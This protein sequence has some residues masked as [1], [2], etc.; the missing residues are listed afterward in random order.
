MPNA[1]VLVA[2][3]GVALSSTALAQFRAADPLETRVSEARALETTPR[4]GMLDWA[5]EFSMTDNLENFPLG[6]LFIDAP[7]SAD[8]TAFTAPPGLIWGPN[9]L[10]GQ[11]VP[12]NPREWTSVVDLANEPVGPANT[13]RGLRIRTDVAQNP[14]GFFVGIRHEWPIL[15]GVDGDTPVRLHADFFATSLGQLYTFE[16]VDTGLSNLISARLLW[17]GD[18]EAHELEINCVELAPA[19]DLNAFVFLSDCLGARCFGSQFWPARYCATRYGNA[20]EGCE[21]PPFAKIGDIVRP[22]VGSW[23]QLGYEISPEGTR[24]HTI[25]YMDGTG[26]HRFAIDAWFI[27][28]PYV[29]RLSVN[30]SF[31][32]ADALLYVDNI[33]ASGAGG[34]LLDQ[35]DFD[36]PFLNDAN[37]LNEGLL[38]GQFQDALVGS[39]GF[40]DRPTAYVVP[41]HNGAPGDLAIAIDPDETPGPQTGLA[42]QAFVPI[43]RAE[44]FDIDISVEVRHDNSR[45]REIALR[46]SSSSSSAGTIVLSHPAQ[47]NIQ[48]AGGEGVQILD[49]QWPSDNEYHSLTLR[50]SNN[51][52]IRVSIDG[53]PVGTAAGVL[54]RPPVVNFLEFRSVRGGLFEIDNVAA[55]CGL[56]SCASDVNLDDVTNFADLNAVLSNF[57]Q[58]GDAVPGDTNLDGTV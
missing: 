46:A 55:G 27:G 5:G 2:A 36:C 18:C 57:G 37:Y 24:S 21:P 20:V 42:L 12:T 33:A 48:V 7:V 58:T 14:G 22:A 23:F 3:V 35:P 28:S 8:P 51:G 10:S 29:N 49:A 26:P 11:G 9:A 43:A 6:R 31:E 52:A 38:A 44:E 16:A 1:S 30:T 39:P 53:Q 40:P 15:L 4:G 45:R 17:G 56:D 19:G 25:D 54:S 47:P 32:D 50:V 34:V 41:R 13:S